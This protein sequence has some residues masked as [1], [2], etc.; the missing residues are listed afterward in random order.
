MRPPDEDASLRTS[1]TNGSSRPGPSDTGYSRQAGTELPHTE[2]EKASGLP[3]EP[4]R[5]DMS[6]WPSRREGAGRLRRRS[7][8][9]FDDLGSDVPELAIGVLG[10]GS[11]QAERLIGRAPL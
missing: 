3:P 4:G 7:T 2:Q 10:M 5:Q 9:A 1:T 6:L 8:D 11:Q